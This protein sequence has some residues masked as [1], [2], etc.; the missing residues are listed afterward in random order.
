MT[1]RSSQ[2]RWWPNSH[3]L[4]GFD[5]FPS[6]SWRLRGSSGTHALGAQLIYQLQCY[7]S[8]PNKS[9][10]S[11]RSDTTP[12]SGRAKVRVSNY[13][14]RL[15]L[16]PLHITHDNNSSTHNIISPSGTYKTRVMDVDVSWSSPTRILCLGTAFKIL[17]QAKAAN[18]LLR[19]G[20]KAKAAGRACY[21]MVRKEL[22][23][24]K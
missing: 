22:N 10:Q 9:A 3:T 19:Q 24:I 8:A 16:S 18:G 15:S 11:P 2:K 17:S 23:I 14:R 20:Q 4:L 5:P 13:V 21:G 7:P 12:A 1:T 6:Y